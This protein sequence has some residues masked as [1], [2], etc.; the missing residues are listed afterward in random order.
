[1]TLT[2]HSSLPLQWSRYE[3][4]VDEF[5]LASEVTDVHLNFRDWKHFVLAD[6]LITSH[7][8]SQIPALARG[9]P[10]LVSGLPMT[11][12]W[13]AFTNRA[14]RDYWV[15][16]KRKRISPGSDEID[17]CFPNHTITAYL[18]FNPAHLKAENEIPIQSIIHAR[19]GY[20]SESNSC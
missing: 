3:N 11:L 15:Q 8:F 19:Y 6:V 5:H 13:N 12:I 14:Y 18:G 16:W 7:T 17:F 4:L 2:L 10:S 20:N 1:M 9:R